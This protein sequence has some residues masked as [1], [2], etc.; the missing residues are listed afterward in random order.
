VTRTAL[1][2]IG[3]RQQKGVFDAPGLGRTTRLDRAVFFIRTACILCVGYLVDH[4]EVTVE[5]HVEI[6]AH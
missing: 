4:G 3:V 2:F 6:R 1:V 5:V